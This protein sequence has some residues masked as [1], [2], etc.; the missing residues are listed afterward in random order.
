MPSNFNGSETSGRVKF[1]LGSQ[2]QG[3]AP[4]GGGLSCCA[5]IP[6]VLLLWARGGPPSPPTPAWVPWAQSGSRGPGSGACVPAPA[7]RRWVCEKREN[8][9]Q[10]RE[11]VFGSAWRGWRR[12]R[13]GCC[14]LDT[15]QWGLQGC[16]AAH[17]GPPGL[18][19]GGRRDL[20]DTPSRAS[21]QEPPA[22]QGH[23]CRVVAQLATA[24]VWGSVTLPRAGR[25]ERARRGGHRTA[26]GP[27][28]AWRRAAPT[29][30]GVGTP[31]RPGTS[32]QEPS[33]GVQ[34]QAALGLARQG[35]RGGRGQAIL[36]SSARR[37]LTPASLESPLPPL[38]RG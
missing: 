27:M 32:K 4:G 38:P 14:A 31:L 8:T 22:P 20:E 35:L 37:R 1:S 26:R 16:G 21:P 15:R 11:W 34:T 25:H 33:P 10:G 36:C 23:G 28:S 7:E 19:P 2:Q 6:G 29:G 24:P 12:R 9:A 3:S 13:G 17:E 5:S 18:A 30:V